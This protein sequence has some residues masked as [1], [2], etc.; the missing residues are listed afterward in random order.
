M[1]N[2]R[3]V[4]FNVW[5]G[6]SPR[7]LRGNLNRLAMDTNYPHVLALQEAKRYDGSISGYQRVAAKGDHPDAQSSILLVRD[8]VEVVTQRHVYVAGP[9]WKGPKHGELHP[10]RTFPA[11]SLEWDLRRWEVMDIHRTGKSWSKESWLAED[12]DIYGWNLLREQRTVCR[13]RIY[14][15]DWNARATMLG[16]TSPRGLARR[17]NGTLALRGIDGAIGV[18]VKRITAKKLSDHYGSD[19]H[20]PVLIEVKA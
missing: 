19:A 5:V 8:D 3:L 15:G 17:M 20:R 12:R 1:S 14:L 9:W 18:N 11:A 7:V 16:R 13:P 6:Q 10:P 4:T 2:L